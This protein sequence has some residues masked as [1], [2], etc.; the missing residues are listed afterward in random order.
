LHG[1]PDVRIEGGMTVN[2]LL[3][4]AVLLTAIALLV[5]ILQL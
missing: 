2:Q 1:F 5:L 4:F 3:I